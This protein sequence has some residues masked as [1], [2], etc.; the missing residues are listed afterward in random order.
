MQTHFNVKQVLLAVKKAEIVQSESSLCITFFSRKGKNIKRKR[1]RKREK[2]ASICSLPP[3]I[4]GSK[5][6]NIVPAYNKRRK[7]Y[8][9]LLNNRILGFPSPL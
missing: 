4:P 6:S 8:F 7:E 5:V 2:G 9:H 3:V 1:K